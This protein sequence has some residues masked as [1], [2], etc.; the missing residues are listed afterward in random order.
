MS[1]NL[2]ESMDEADNIINLLDYEYDSDSIS[3]T[4]NHAICYS[5]TT[6]TEADDSHLTAYV[7]T[8]GQNWRTV[9]G[10]F[11]DRSQD[12]CRKRW[13]EL[14][15]KN[16]IKGPWTF[17]EDEQIIELVKT[18]GP[19]KWTVIAS[20]LKGRLGKQCRERW[21]NHLNPDINKN[22]WTPFED[23]V[24]CE[25]HFRMGNR[26]ATISKLLPGRTDNAIKN[27]WNSSLRK[28]N[29]ALSVLQARAR[30]HEIRAILSEHNFDSKNFPCPEEWSEVYDNENICNNI[31]PSKLKSPQ[32]LIDRKEFRFLD[33]M[34]ILSNNYSRDLI[35]VPSL[36]EIRR[37]CNEKEKEELDQKK[38][39]PSILRKHENWNSLFDENNPIDEESKKNIIDYLES[40]IPSDIRM[41]RKVEN[42]DDEKNVRMPSLKHKHILSGTKPI[43][44]KR[45][46]DFYKNNSFSKLFNQN[47]KLFPFDK[48]WL[49]IAC[50]KTE[51]QLSL[52]SLAK[53][54][55]RNNIDNDL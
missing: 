48:K 8:Y 46:S 15:N 36:K 31:P 50:G 53:Q 26:W 33:S 24:I 11:K 54:Y 4:D 5:N 17:E 16:I 52:T 6:W 47:S 23:A 35:N 12:D 34:E 28:K 38:G 18:Y 39:L 25:A 51:D 29:E 27:H 55:F 43:K 19:K 30:R 49:S 20:H 21:H 7:Q 37:K 13:I 41:D 22:P 9:S 32:K 10:M 40:I 44:K 3:M 2:V 14:S 45:L 1:D 42:I